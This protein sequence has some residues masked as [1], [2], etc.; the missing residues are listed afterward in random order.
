MK[1][2]PWGIFRLALIMA[3]AAAVLACSG[4][5]PVSFPAELREATV[6]QQY[7]GAITAYG[8]TGELAALRITLTG[9]L[10]P[11]LTFSSTDNGQAQIT[12]IPTTA[13]SYTF[14]VSAA[15]YCT[16]G[17]CQRGERDYTLVVK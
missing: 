15:G 1:R 13:G 14:K 5:S 17:G 3:L 10:P 8:N 4:D 2:L 12:G 11:G 16:M 9:S 6:G 7:S